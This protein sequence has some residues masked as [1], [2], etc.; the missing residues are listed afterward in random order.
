MLDTEER[1]INTHNKASEATK[2]K[3][4]TLKILMILGSNILNSLIS[5][6]TQRAGFSTQIL[7]ERRELRFKGSH[8]GED[9]QSVT[10]HYRNLKGRFHTKCQVCC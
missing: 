3:E 6:C 4:N 9:K 2:H 7:T 10:N 8:T 5:H 1:V